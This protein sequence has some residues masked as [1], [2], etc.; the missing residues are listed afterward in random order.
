M[1]DH[2]FPLLPEITL[3]LPER[4]ILEKLMFMKDHASGRTSVNC[5]IMVDF[6]KWCQS[7]TSAS[8]MR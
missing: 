6:K 7:W 1:K 5:V 2:V 3:G 8:T 4:D